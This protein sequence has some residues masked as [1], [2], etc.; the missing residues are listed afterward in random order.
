MKLV[1][2]RKIVFFLRSNT[3]IVESGN[4]GSQTE[5]ESCRTTL[6]A[7]MT[8]LGRKKKKS[9]TLQRQYGPRH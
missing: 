3:G 4:V 2:R 6:G 1:A 8:N 9:A 7:K 5:Q